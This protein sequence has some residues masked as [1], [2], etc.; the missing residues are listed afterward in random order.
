MGRTYHNGMNL[1]GETGEEHR[2]TSVQLRMKDKQIPS[3]GGEPQ[4]VLVAL[5]K[6][7]ATADLAGCKGLS[8]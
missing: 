3:D 7:G 6:N 1:N 4:V 2:H 5:R 8:T